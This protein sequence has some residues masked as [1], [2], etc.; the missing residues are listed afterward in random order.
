MDWKTWLRRGTVSAL[1]ALCA[2]VH[3]VADADAD[4]RPAEVMLL[5][6]FHFR[7]AH[8]HTM[9]VDPVDVMAPE[10]QAYLALLAQ[11]LCEYRPTVVVVERDPR[12][13]GLL[14]QAFEAYRSGGA[15]LDRNETE[16]LGF[17]IA[18]ACGVDR[19]QGFNE[20]EVQWPGESIVPFI[21]RADPALSD[22]LQAEIAAFE[23]DDRAAHGHETLRELLL[24][25][26]DPQQDRRN[27]DLY[28]LM[29]VAGAGRGFEGADANALW[30][31]RNLR[32]YANLQRLARP[33][34]RLL[35]IAGQGH[36]AMLRGFL[37]VDRRLVARDVRPFL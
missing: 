4:A 32:M 30:W 9:D 13:D 22:R 6:T 3:G 14:Q 26:N 19:V 25:Y 27:L 18:K 24:R 7:N 23:T 12:Q 35:V 28:L 37:A 5:G 8:N 21:R 17:R 15:A 2:G 1:F 11:R 36:T 29:N 31:Q 20:S 34:E 10:H 33:G 16:Q